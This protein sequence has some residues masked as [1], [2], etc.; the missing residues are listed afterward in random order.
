MMY[1]AIRTT[2]CSALWSEAKQLPYEVVMQQALDSVA[3]ELI[4]DLRTHVS[5]LW[6]TGERSQEQES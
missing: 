6:V 3:I 2:V 4:E 5:R 1:C